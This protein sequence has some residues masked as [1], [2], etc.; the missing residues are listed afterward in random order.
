[1]RCAWSTCG[2]NHVLLGQ[3]LL[4][5]MH[6]A[7]HHGSTISLM[8]QTDEQTGLNDNSILVITV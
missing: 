8:Q 7:V 3:D 1:M 6:A 2:R 5:V 4:E